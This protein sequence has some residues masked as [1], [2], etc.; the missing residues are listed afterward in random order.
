[1]HCLL[2]VPKF[3]FFVLFHYVIIEAEK[4][5]EKNIIIF[6]SISLVFFI[7]VTALFSGILC[8]YLKLKRKINHV[9]NINLNAGWLMTVT[10]VVDKAQNLIYCFLHMS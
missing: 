8:F 5:K 9:P 2:V 10:L 1:M 3:C 7:A 4:G 6:T